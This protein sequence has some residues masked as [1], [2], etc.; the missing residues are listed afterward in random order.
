MFRRYFLRNLSIVSAGLALPVRGLFA[1]YHR[2]KQPLVKGRVTAGGKGLQGVGISDGFDIVQTNKDGYYSLQVHSNARFVFIILPAGYEIPNTDGVA[3]FY[4]SI[5]ALQTGQTINFSLR[6]LALSDEKHAFIVWGDTQ[7]YDKED[8]LQLI[9]I[10]APF[11]RKLAA[12]MGNTPLH[13]ISLG[14]L[15]FD[16]FELFPDY[17]EAIAKTGVAFFQLI[18]NHDMDPGAR[19]DEKSDHTFQA[20]FGPTWYSFNR[21]RAHYIVMDNVFNYRTSRGYIGYLPEGQLA[22]LEKDLALVP[23]GSLVMVSMHI[24]TKTGAAR[25]AGQ[26]EEALWSSLSNRDVLYKMLKPYKA[27]IFSAHTHV[28]ENWEEGD[29]M[30]HNHATVCGAWWTGPVCDDGTPQGMA[31]YYVD[32]DKLSWR[33][34]PTGDEKGRQFTMY[35]PGE[36]TERPHC[37][38]ANVW[39]WDPA[40][41]VE[42]WQDG[43]AMGAMEQFVGRDPL[44][45]K[46]YKG[47]ELPVKHK[48]VEPSLTG[49][50]FATS[51]LGEA[52]EILVK[53][54]DRF[55]QVFEE[56]LSI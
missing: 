48:W 52:K 16:K 14:D 19:S 54:T 17:R 50:L 42:W 49:H 22:W 10:S 51:P 39:N 41:K 47:A 11:T 24:P 13:G 30:E 25:R 21:G 56:R 7:I 32:G 9:E 23:A 18:G 35:P 26:K 5:D 55:G 20:N 33:F 40:W 4:Q 38:V 37:I 8:A 46:L 29:L 44:A 1:S 3:A 43:N 12:S 28:N 36:S 6:P 34:Y 15:V 53:V 31:A 2:L 27:H 45:T